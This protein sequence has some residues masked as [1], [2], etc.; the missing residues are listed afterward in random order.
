VIGRS[1]K[2]PVRES[3]TAWKGCAGFSRILVDANTFGGSPPDADRRWFCGLP[4]RLVSNFILWF[5]PSYCS[6]II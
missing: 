6:S 5:S 3:A 4:S 1:D 2:L